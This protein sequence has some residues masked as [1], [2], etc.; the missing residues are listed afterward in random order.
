[1]RHQ[2]RI[3]KLNRT[4]SHRH[5]MLGNLAVSLLR[6]HRVETSAA[7]AMAVRPVVERLITYGKRGDLHARRTA[8]RIIHDHEILQKL[9]QEIA[10]K[11]QE[12]NGGYTRVLKTGFRVGDCCPMAIIELVGMAQTQKEVEET[13]DKKGAKQAPK[14]A[15]TAPAAK[16]KEKP[17]AKEE[18]KDAKKDDKKE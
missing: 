14:E 7:K 11:Y 4:A 3:K 2:N 17:K 5:A 6:L 16:K 1:M 15:P 10:P 18:K 9:F 8:A 12:R 13:P